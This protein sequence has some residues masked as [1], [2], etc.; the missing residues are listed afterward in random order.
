MPKARLI[1]WLLGAWGLVACAAA[2][3]MDIPKEIPDEPFDITAARIEYTNETI[4]ASGGVTGR[5][6]MP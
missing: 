5:F 3:D 4:I 1:R 6:E 2:L